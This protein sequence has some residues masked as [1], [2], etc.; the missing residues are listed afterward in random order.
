MLVI[1]I[2]GN[3]MFEL[4]YFDNFDIWDSHLSRVLDES[5]SP[6][7]SLDMY[8]LITMNMDQQILIGNP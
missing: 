6:N 3:Q 5:F 8:F 1:G 7:V 4:N 2:P